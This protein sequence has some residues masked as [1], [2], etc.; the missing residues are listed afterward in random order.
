MKKVIADPITNDKRKRKIN[1]LR[2]LFR[3]KSIVE[4]FPIVLRKEKS[5]V[6]YFFYHSNIFI[7]NVK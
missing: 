7:K 3:M 4:K 1:K 2:N 5:I 6:E